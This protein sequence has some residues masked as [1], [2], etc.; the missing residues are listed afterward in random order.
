M[1]GLLDM[2]RRDQ[3]KALGA[4]ID[5]GVLAKDVDHAG[6]SA[7]VA[8]NEVDGLGRENFLEGSGDA[9][10]FADVI[11]SLRKREGGG[12]AVNGDALADV[13]KFGLRK[14][15][16]KFGLTGEEDL[17]EFVAGGFQIEEQAELF[18]GLGGEALG[19]VDDQNRSEAGAIAFEKP[20]VECD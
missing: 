1:G 19:F 17:E 16:V 11:L 7:S 3:G 6:N 13:A 8:V 4:G 12:A 20:I 14:L 9:K 10:A 2:A 18:E 5:E 15:V